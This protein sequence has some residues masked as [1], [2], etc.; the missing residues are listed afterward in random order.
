MLDDPTNVTTTSNYE[1]E[2]DEDDLLDGEDLSVIPPT[3]D[4]GTAVA[5]KKKRA[6]K[7]CTCGLADGN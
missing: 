7:D 3:E 2:I 4:C 5:G 6:C 1:D